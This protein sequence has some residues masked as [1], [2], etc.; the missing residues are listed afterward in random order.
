MADTPEEPRRST[1]ANVH[2]TFVKAVFSR[3]ENAVGL[4]EAALPPAV[5]A[6]LDLETLEHRP[7]SFAGVTS[8][9]TDLLFGVRLAGRETLLYVLLEHKST[10]D[11]PLLPV[12]LLVYLGR[13]WDA[14]LRENDALPAERRATRAPAI[15]PLVLFHG[16]DGWRS[17]TEL[18]DVIDLDPALRELLRP[19][20]P[21][22]RF[23]IDDLVART[24]MDLR[25][26]RA[27][28][29]G[30]LALLLLRHLRE[31]RQD[32]ARVLR[33][34]RTVADLFNLLPRD[35]RVLCFWYILKVAKPEPS[36]VQSA[37][38]DVVEPAVLEDVMTAGEKIE[39]EGQKKGERRMFL[40]MARSRFGD[41]PAGAERRILAAD[42]GELERWARR[43]FLAASLDEL[44]G[45]DR[46]R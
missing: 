14:W 1:A 46:A 20:L 43:L 16:P 40:R 27:G 15:V 2:D 32:P 37:L 12:T 42:D 31:R 9:H 11:D 10:D 34:L 5:F 35:D 8:R 45:P 3:R 13:I 30:R 33:F 36:A 29:L 39:A 7:G 28:V 24:D 4:L 6:A 22:Y 17:T 23:A 25:A 18:V 38:Q 44:L 19:H 26:R 21:S 41:L